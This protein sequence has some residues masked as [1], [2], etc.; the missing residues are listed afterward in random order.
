MNSAAPDTAHLRHPANPDP[1][2]ATARILRALGDPTRLR[3][4]RAMSID[5]RSVS[6][7]VVGSGLP[8]PL[9]SHHLGILRESGLARYERRG[10]YKFY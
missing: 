5:C 4:L 2:P 3:L 9:V 1:N 7:L 10:A 6:Q 8:Q